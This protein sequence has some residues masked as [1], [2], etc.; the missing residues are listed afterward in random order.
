M[1]LRTLRCPG[2]K[3]QSIRPSRTRLDD[4]PFRLV[5]MRAYRCLVCDRRF[6]TWPVQ[7]S[8]V[9]G[10]WPK[11]RAESNEDPCTKQQRLLQTRSFAPGRRTNYP[12]QTKLRTTIESEFQ[13]VANENN[14]RLAPLT[15]DLELLIC[16]LDSLGFATVVTRLED[17]LGFDPFASVPEDVFFPQTFGEF[18]RFYENAPR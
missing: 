10:A 13:R 2:C 1:A 18:V 5:G 11:E 17:T 9:A 6:H 16:G 3:V 14:K 12:V 4:L 15:D 7:Q 8:A